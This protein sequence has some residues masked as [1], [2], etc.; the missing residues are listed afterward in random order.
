MTLCK[1]AQCW[2]QTSR[3]E[4]SISA[5]WTAPQTAAPWTAPQPAAPWTESE[6]PTIQG[7][8]RGS[9][10]SAQ[11]IKDPRNVPPLC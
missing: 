7:H 2:L 9:T 11:R 1:S 6:H 8:Y 3:V 10:P 4:A 5:P